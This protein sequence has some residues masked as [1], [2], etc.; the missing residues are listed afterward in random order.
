MLTAG[1]PAIIGNNA[2]DGVPFVPYHLTGPTNQTQVLIALLTTFFCPTTETIRL[3]QETDRLTY[4]YL[5]AGNFSNISPKPWMGA[6]HSSELPLLMGTHP[7]FRGPSTPL[8]YATSHAFQ[9]AYVAFAS[10]PVNG[11]A[12]QDWTPYTQLGADNVREFGAGVAAQ[13]TSVGSTEALCNG[14]VPAAPL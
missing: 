6:Y 3:R 2:Q 11:L 12:N 5:Y 7:D 8:E 1:Q 13:D 10:D 14:P 4:R 9:D